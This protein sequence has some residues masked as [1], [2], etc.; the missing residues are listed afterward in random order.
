MVIDNTPISYMILPLSDHGLVDFSQ[1]LNTEQGTRYSL[2]GSKFVIKWS[3]VTP[4]F[5]KNLDSSAQGPYTQAQILQ[6]L[7]APEW[8]E[9]EG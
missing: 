1:L 7:S 6:I 5:V 9:S 2:D 8:E 4:S 3:D